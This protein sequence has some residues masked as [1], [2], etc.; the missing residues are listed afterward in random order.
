MAADA[1]AAALAAD[2]ARAEASE[3]P[4]ACYAL[5]TLGGRNDEAQRLL[6]ARAPALPWTEGEGMGSYP[7]WRRAAPS[8]GARAAADARS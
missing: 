8:P 5:N 3:A 2:A 1:P 7:N 6:R 4:E